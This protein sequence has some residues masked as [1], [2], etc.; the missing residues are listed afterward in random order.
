MKI[1][2][3]IC[4]LLP[5]GAVSQKIVNANRITEKISIDGY[6]NETG[7]KSAEMV[8]DF[9]QLKPIPGAKSTK[10]TEVRVLYDDRAIYFSAI[11]Y[12]NPDSISRVLSARDDYN[13]NLDLFGIFIDTYND[14]QN[15]FFFGA[16]SR[17]VQL[18]AKIFASGWDDALNLVWQSS[19]KIVADAWIVEIEIPFSS[20]R[21][22]KSEVQDWG[23]NFG[24]DISRFREE[25]FWTEVKPDLENFLL[26]S[27]DIKGLKN[28]DP[29][30][31]LALM[32]YLSSYFDRVPTENSFNNSGSINGGLDIKYG[33][34]EAFTLDLTLV[35]DFGQV[36][37][38]QN[39]LN[40][41]PFEIQF[42]E[43]RQF[44]IEGTELFNKA[45]LF[46]SRRIGVQAPYEVGVF[47]LNENETLEETPAP[48]Q[49][50]NASKL[51]GRLNNGLGIAFFN[52]VTME[53][54]GSAFDSSLN[55]RREVL[56]SPLTNYNVFVLDQNLKNNSSLTFTNT[57]V[58]RAG[59]AYDANVSGLNFRLNSKDNNYYMNGN[60]ALSAKISEKNEFGYSYSL[61]AGKQRG[62]FIYGLIYVEESDTY[63]PNDLGFNYNNNRR[64][65][66]ISFS[67]RNFK[68][69]WQKLN[70]I[71]LSTSASITGLYNPNRFT[72]AYVNSSFVLVFKSFDA[73]G[74]NSNLALVESYD[75]F[76]PRKWGSYFIR[77]VSSNF[78]AWISSNYQKRF[79]FD[80]RGDYSFV[81]R[82][83][84]NEWNYN[85]SP[86]VRI[87]N[88]LFLK[89][90]WEQ[91]FELNSQA[92][93]V[94]FETPAENIPEIIFGKRDRINTT[95]AISVDY[96]ITNRMSMTFRLR[97]YRSSIEYESFFS[98]NENGRLSPLD[99]YS[100]LTANGNSAYNINYNA[101]TIDLQ[102]RWVFMPASEI[103][104]VW[105]NAIFS[106][107]NRVNESYF[108]NLQNTFENGPMNS[109]SFKIIY[110][111]DASKLKKKK[112][113]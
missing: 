1:R 31:R 104:L 76:E 91:N 69:K 86:R 53:Q 21:F 110:W 18:D 94:Q 60:S 25:T 106:S 64:V 72:G 84:W 51:S 39:V 40:L 89:Y 61:N 3:L 63:D 34:N 79:A 77:P 42:N 87:T 46:Y 49:L 47:S 58:L 65:G 23:I 112:T 98:L 99:T 80:L 85:F 13:S 109:F 107:D 4:L 10:E 44:F 81:D 68:P 59:S 7:W 54:K 66:D 35:P 111:L 50:L 43:N 12:D 2:L 108:T 97:H 6:L 113:T 56:V 9:I 28:I 62:N 24:R 82:A 52:A 11:C 83:D 29:P 20:L 32:P 70:K 101:F 74:L 95:Q 33:L 102:Y 75:F 27:G 19:V 73:L 96:I 67:Y 55:S 88:F 100:G 57:N 16:T 17:G 103:N 37:F 93:A 5:L 105:K 71:S 8:S 38:D 92:Y 26:N 90:N 36:V 78:G 22:P 41:S 30:L 48:P 15:G 45:G 14:E